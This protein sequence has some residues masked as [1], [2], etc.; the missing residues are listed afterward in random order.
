MG[1]Y[2]RAYDFAPN[3][4]KGIGRP[5]LLST[6]RLIKLMPL[7]SLDGL[8]APLRG[9][10]RSEVREDFLHV[11]AIVSL[12]SRCSWDQVAAPLV[13]SIVTAGIRKSAA[14][15]NR[16]LLDYGVLLI[17]P[18]IAA[19]VVMPVSFTSDSLSEPFI[20]QTSPIQFG[21]SKPFNPEEPASSK[22]SPD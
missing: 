2:K 11:V 14:G 3:L 15:Y 12:V 17:H 20:S 4:N 7:V 21:Q 1:S 13:K 16:R 5:S 8:D 18:T 6:Q 10:R 19:S 22:S 9:G